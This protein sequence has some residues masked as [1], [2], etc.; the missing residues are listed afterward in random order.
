MAYEDRKVIMGSVIFFI[1]CV[2]VALGLE[3]L[4][5]KIGLT[6][7]LTNCSGE[8]FFLTGLA[9]S[10]A[11]IYLTAAVYVATRAI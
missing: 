3:P 6:R 9:L 8:M 10:T 11:L 7:F 5:N 1:Y 2:L 4:S